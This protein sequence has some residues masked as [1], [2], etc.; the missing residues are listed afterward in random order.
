GPQQR[1]NIGLVGDMIKL[2]WPAY[3]DFN[4][5]LRFNDGLDSGNWVP[6]GSPEVGDGSIKTYQ[7]SVGDITI[8]RF[9]SLLVEENQ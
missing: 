5:L 9:W 7:V 1:L 6:I 4:Y 2:E 8:P 3:P